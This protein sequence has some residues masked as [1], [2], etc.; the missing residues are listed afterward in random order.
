MASGW[1]G[2]WQLPSVPTNGSTIDEDG[3]DLW[4]M[5]CLS[6]FFF[7]FSFFLLG[8]FFLI[9]VNFNHPCF[10]IRTNTCRLRWNQHTMFCI[11]WGHWG[12]MNWFRM[13]THTTI[14]IWNGT[15]TQAFHVAMWMY[16][17]FFQKFF[18]SVTCSSARWLSLWIYGNVNKRRWNWDNCERPQLSLMW[19]IENVSWLH[20]TPCA[21]CIISIFSMILQEFYYITPI[22]PFFFYHFPLFSTRP[23]SWQIERDNIRPETVQ[24]HNKELKKDIAVIEWQWRIKYAGDMNDVE[25]IQDKALP[26]EQSIGH[27]T[28]YHTQIGSLTNKDL[29]VAENGFRFGTTR[30]FAALGTTVTSRRWLET[31]V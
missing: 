22:F 8:F 1:R 23:S 5:C 14:A 11:R 29:Y 9:F 19:T 28:W 27:A 17:G 3:M 2:A 13:V 21:W 25:I 30:L 18:L 24:M 15:R 7:F 10:P 4:M 26:F 12:C 16:S 20:Y 31:T 6:T